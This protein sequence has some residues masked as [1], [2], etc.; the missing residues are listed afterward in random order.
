MVKQKKV[1]YPALFLAL[2][3]GFYLWLMRPAVL[4]QLRGTFKAKPI[5]SEYIAFKNFITKQPNFFR[6]FWISK[7]QRFG[8]WS[9]HHPGVDAEKFFVENYCQEPFCSLRKE[10]PEKWGQ[11]C[12]SNDRCYVRELA[13][14]LNPKTA[15]LLSKMAVKYIVVP[16]DSEGEI[17]LAERKYNPQQREEVEKFLDTISWLKKIEGFGK[18]AVYETPGHKDHF[19]LEK[20]GFLAEPK[21]GSWSLTWKMI[22]PTKYKIQVRNATQPLR[23]VF[24]ETHH[25]LW[26]IKIGEKLIPSKATDENLNSF[27]VNQ[28]G[29]FEAEV[30]FG[31]QKY[32]TLGSIISLVAFLMALGSLVYLLLF[33]CF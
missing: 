16:Y 27:L 31:A 22:N 10:I 23:F 26:R 30:E 20:V 9:N 14:F 17:F 18:I 15:E 1:V 21:D 28:A 12:L 11:D 2:F 24:S 19:W 4:G 13:Y 33:P 29:D 25:A 32:V 5:P 8:F 7:R 6:V 3:L